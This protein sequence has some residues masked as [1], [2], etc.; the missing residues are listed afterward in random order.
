M[1]ATCPDCGAQAH[2][3]A[4]FMDDEG[5]RLAM[6]MACMAPPL[7]RSVLGYLR[8]FKP[9]GSALRM[10]RASGIA[11]EVAAMASSGV[12]FAA[13][14]T[15]LSRPATTAHWAAGI[16]T[17]LSKRLSVPLVGHALLQDEVYRLAGRPESVQP[18]TRE[19]AADGGKSLTPA[20]VTGITPSPH[21]ESPLERQLKWIAHQQD[22]GGFTAEE[23]DAERASARERYGST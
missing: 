20:R 7:A 10:A 16:E 15:G 14:E 5:K 22:L 12:V 21:N 3:S 4:F 9:A 13:G 6:I 1:R 17:L 18:G 11:Q 23:A 8:L 19:V 2:V